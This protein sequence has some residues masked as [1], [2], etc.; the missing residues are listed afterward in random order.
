M[1]PARKYKTYEGIH[2][3]MEM[4]VG[5]WLMI[6][7]ATIGVGCSVTFLGGIMGCIILPEDALGVVCMRRGAPPAW[8]L[9]L[10]IGLQV[11]PWLMIPVVLAGGAEAAN[12]T[13]TEWL[14]AMNEE[15]RKKQCPTCGQPTTDRCPTCGQPKG[16]TRSTT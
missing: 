6:L 15:Q 16:A 1:P 13:V 14:H 11:T 7:A 9:P 5:F 2:G 10:V 8:G 3:T 12:M 4:N